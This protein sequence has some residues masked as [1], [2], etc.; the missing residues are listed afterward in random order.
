MPYDVSR[1]SVMLRGSIGLVKLGQPQPDSYL[2][3]EAKRGS[4]DTISTYMPG[5]L[6]CRCSPVPGRSVAFSWVTLYCSGVSFAMASGSLR[7]F[8]IVHLRWNRRVRTIRSER[9]HARQIDRPVIRAPSGRLAHSGPARCAWRG[10]K[11]GSAS[12]RFG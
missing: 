9:A 4:P 10:E 8:G 6:L 3:E 7:Y 11:N 5:S 2:S 12:N 1:R